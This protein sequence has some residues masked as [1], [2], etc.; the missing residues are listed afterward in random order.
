[1]LALPEIDVDL[2]LAERYE[3]IVFG[4]A[5]DGEAQPEGERA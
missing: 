2:Q 5:P 4:D 1:M 3:G